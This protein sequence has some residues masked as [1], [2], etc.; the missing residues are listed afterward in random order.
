MPSSYNVEMSYKPKHDNKKVKEWS[1]IIEQDCVEHRM[2]AQFLNL[3]QEPVTF[4]PWELDP[5]L[6]PK[7]P[8][9]AR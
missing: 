7:R 5:G 4:Q 1:R 2:L 9:G 8:P 6:L 3:P